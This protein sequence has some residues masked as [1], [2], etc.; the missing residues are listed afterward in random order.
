V[1]SV[2]T[3]SE[4]GPVWALIED[5]K[6]SRRTGAVNAARASATVAR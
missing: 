4:A 1:A 5:M 3:T 6:I 2:S